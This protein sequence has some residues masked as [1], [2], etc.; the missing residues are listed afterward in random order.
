METG[1]K[2]S[3]YGQDYFSDCKPEIYY[4]FYLTLAQMLIELYN[5]KR[6]LDIGCGLGYLVDAFNGLG[7]RAHGI[8]F[9][10]YA[11]SH[12]PPLIRNKL[13]NIDLEQEQEWPFPPV[14]FELTVSLATFEHLKNPAIAI[15]EIERT[16]K[17]GGFALI[18]V[19]SPISNT[20]NTIMRRYKE[21][22]HV[23]VLPRDKWIG[24]FEARNLFYQGNLNMIRAFRAIKYTSR[25]RK[26]LLHSPL[27]SLYARLP[28]NLVFRKLN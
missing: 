17:V 8:D 16:L 18:T 15:S 6:V 13:R 22:T 23:S 26:W 20:L 28:Y 9:S 12:C 7:I 14:Y 24:L 3:S 27:V 25:L 2:Q 5:P 19:P 21:P 4:P 1:I 11:L 10:E